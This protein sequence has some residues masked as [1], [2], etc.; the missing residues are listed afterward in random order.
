M[1]LLLLLLQVRDLEER[2]VEKEHEL[3]QMRRNLDESEGAIA[4]VT[5]RSPPAIRTSASPLKS[6]PAPLPPR[7]MQVFEGKQRLWEKEVEELKRLYA[8]KLRQVT[9]HAQ[10]A[11]RSQRGL[12]LQLFKAQQEKSR[13]QEAGR[14]EEGGAMG[15]RTGPTLEETQWEV[16]GGG[17]LSQSDHNQSES[18]SCPSGVPEVR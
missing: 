5:L 17:F 12:Q 15:K 16:G 6:D 3:K 10:H 7:S 18:S 1:L 13:L 4:Q 2:L 14:S 8:A 9:Q 11:Q